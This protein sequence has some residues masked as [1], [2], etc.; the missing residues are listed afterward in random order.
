MI[1]QKLFNYQC[2]QKKRFLHHFDGH[3]ESVSFGLNLRHFNNQ[4]LGFGETRFDLVHLVDVPGEHVGSG[5]LLG[6]RLPLSLF[7]PLSLRMF[8]NVFAL[9]LQD[10]VKNG[11]LQFLRFV[12]IG[13][14][15]ELEPLVVVVDGD[16]AAHVAPDDARFTPSVQILS[17]R[18]RSLTAA[19][20]PKT[21]DEKIL[22]EKLN[23]FDPTMVKQTAA[24]VHVVKNGR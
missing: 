12:L 6:H 10:V 16:L 23:G 19:I 21:V 7:V 17:S 2:F 8:F 24:P 9:N 1:F 11:D 14:N 22:V 18:R 20:I 5:E 13:W 15:D 4:I 3:I